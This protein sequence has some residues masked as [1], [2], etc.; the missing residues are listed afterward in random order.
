FGAG[1]QGRALRGVVAT[2]LRVAGTI[3]SPRGRLANAARARRTLRRHRGARPVLQCRPSSSVPG[4]GR[5]FR[6]GP[7]AA[8]LR[9]LHGRC[10]RLGHMFRHRVDMTAAW[11]V[12]RVLFAFG[13][14]ATPGPSH[15]VMAASGLAHGFVR[16]IP[17]MAG[18]LDGI[19]ALF[20]LC[21]AGV[22]AVIASLPHGV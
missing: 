3:R 20:M 21:A 8:P 4:G 9:V 2:R 12:S 16:T 15:V 18:T 17:L 5:A 6:A 22:G 11:F 19:A 13:M 10:R 14:T 7:Y 1:G